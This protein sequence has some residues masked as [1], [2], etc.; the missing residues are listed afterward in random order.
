MAHVWTMG[1]TLSGKTAL[2]KLI[3]THL[4][5]RGIAT[6]VLDPLRDGG[7]DADFITHDP[8]RYFS[9]L[10][11]RTPNERCALFLEEAGISVDRDDRRF[12]L[13]LTTGRHAGWR[14]YLISHRF[15]QPHPLVRDMCTERWVFRVSGEDAQQLYREYGKPQLRELPNLPPLHFFRIRPFRPL[16]RGSLVFGR[17]SSPK[18]NLTDLK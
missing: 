15:K 8:D 12:H 18:L 7:W 10:L 13:A 9:W 11:T 2:N 17:G 14:I 6:A 1:E 3:C 5:K 16:Q 4:R